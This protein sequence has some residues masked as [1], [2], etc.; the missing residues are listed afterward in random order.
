[1]EWDRDRVS[2]VC[3]EILFPQVLQVGQHLFD[4]LLPPLGPPIIREGIIV[5]MMGRPTR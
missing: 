2:K 5:M 4:V 3:A 1:M